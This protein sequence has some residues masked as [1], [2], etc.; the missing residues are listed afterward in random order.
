METDSASFELLFFWY[1]VV[2][3]VL[4]C[5]SCADLDGIALSPCDRRSNPNWRFQSAGFVVSLAELSL[6][7]AA[8]LSAL[9]V[10]SYSA[11]FFCSYVVVMGVSKTA[12]LMLVVN[13]PLIWVDRLADFCTLFVLPVDLWSGMR[14]D[15]HS[16]P[17]VE[18]EA[19][20]FL[21]VGA[22]CFATA[23]YV[24]PG[25]KCAGASVYRVPED[26]CISR[27]DVCPSV[28]GMG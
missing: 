26:V 2:S 23:E 5:P 15:V 14:D 13:T 1:D 12:P 19:C 28:N 22:L 18:P 9:L 16:T 21:V 4:R 17:V 8:S 11:T 20:W 27:T 6:C 7:V 10:A 3:Y 25:M 24:M